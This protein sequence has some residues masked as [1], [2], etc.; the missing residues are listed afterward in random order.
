MRTGLDLNTWANLNGRRESITEETSSGPMGGSGESVVATSDLP[1][2]TKR[3]GVGLGTISMTPSRRLMSTT[4]PA[5][6]F[7]WRRS[8]MGT[9]RR[10]APSMV[11]FMP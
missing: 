2:R 4:L 9:T 3:M 7:S 1:R 6:S 8:P 10:P 11:V 5:T